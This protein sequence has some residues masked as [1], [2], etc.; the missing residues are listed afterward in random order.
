MQH[1]HLTRQIIRCATHVHRTLGNGFHE[2]IYQRALAIEFE[3]ENLSFERESEIGIYYRDRNIGIRHVDFF[4]AQKI[5]VELKAQANLENVNVTQ[6]LNYL[7]VF[8]M[9]I[10]L[11][12]NFGGRSLEF[13][14]IHTTTLDHLLHRDTSPNDYNL[15]QI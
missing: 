10:G 15:Q 8:K 9:Q 3:L 6:S 12:I 7:E 1:E 11:L 4:V 14:R 2:V 13:K 5:M